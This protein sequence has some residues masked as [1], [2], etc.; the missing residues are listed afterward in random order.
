MC[1]KKSHWKE[2]MGELENEYF[3]LPPPVSALTLPVKPDIFKELFLIFTM[4]KYC[5][6]ISDS[7]L[8]TGLPTA[9]CGV[10]GMLC[11]CRGPCR[12]ATA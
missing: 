2:D 4:R 5:H 11:T 7:P 12:R 8:Q 3:N 1:I 9:L 6:T 10:K